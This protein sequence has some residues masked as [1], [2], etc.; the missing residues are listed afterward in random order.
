[1]TRIR[2]LYIAAI[3]GAALWL[4]FAGSRPARADDDVQV[5][6]AISDDETDV[7]QSVDYTI[8]V[9][10]AAD[11]S[12]P[13]NI[14]VQG[15]NITYVGPNTQTQISFG[16][17]FGSGGHIERSVVHTYSVVAQQPGE[18]TIPAQQVVVDGVTYK[19]HP[20]DLR[21][22]GSATAGGGDANGPLYYAEF[23]VPRN[24]AYIGEALPVEVKFYLDAR[25]RGQLEEQPEITAAG[26]TVQKVTKPAQS[27]VMRDGKQYIVLTYKTAVTA[28]TAGKVSVGPVTMQLLAQL[29]Q[30]GHRR[31]MGGPFDDPMFQNPFFDDAFQ[32]MSPPQQIKVQGDAVDLTIRPLPAEGQPASFAGAVGNFTL[33]STVKPKMVEAGDPLT[34]TATISG[35]GDFDRVTAPE[36]ADPTG[37]KTYPPSSKVQPDDDVG[38]SGSKTFQLAAI[39]ETQKTESPS[40]VWSYFDPD[41]QQ[42][43]TLTAKGEPI[44]IEGQL[45]T[46]A[47]V[48]A[49]QPAAAA[50]P[51][52]AQSGPDIS[53]IRADSAGWGKT[54]APLYTSPVFWAAQGAPLA[55][56]LAFAG[57]Q[58]ARKRAADEA[59]R[60]RDQWRRA[61]DAEFAA[62]NR[63]DIPESDLYQAAA[64][65]L[66]LDAA[67]Q[68]GRAPELIDPS[69]VASVRVLDG[70][71]A[72]RVREIFDR[73]AEV[74][75]AGASG[76]RAA[77]SAQSRIELLETLKGYENA[78]PVE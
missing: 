78:K 60:R 31:H 58:V 40:L 22:G 20:V 19:T 68:T 56:L 76:S 66:R 34:I 4:W 18:Y 37:W 2:S 55:A 67:I 46:A 50:A 61:R 48:I 23:V 69:E 29:P 45:Q 42:Y 70:A 59:A 32:A 8:T 77:A 21:V 33:S 14:D 63:R 72:E 10:G 53:Y 25:I 73:Q 74:L 49:Q 52:P 38:I 39:P 41:R 64:R 24:T 11:A 51:T 3:L 15:L 35:Q 16:T 47:P 65:V 1:M 62:M 9:N 26:C 6:A 36:L 27:Q 43:V 13:E 75:Y 71:T 12:V 57:V 17:G 28:A 54:F 44:K 7:G 5:S 30:A